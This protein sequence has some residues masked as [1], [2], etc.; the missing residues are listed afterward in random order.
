MRRATIPWACALLVNCG[1]IGFDSSPPVS[2][3]DSGGQTGPAACAP[4]VTGT[5]GATSPFARVQ[6]VPSN[7]AEGTSCQIIQEASSQSQTIS[8][9][10]GN[11]L[12]AFAYGGQA[13]NTSPG[14]TAPNM[15]FT[16]TDTLGNTYLPGS[17]VNNA[18][19][20]DSAIQMFFVPNVRGGANTVTVTETAPQQEDFWTGL[21]LLEYSGVATTDVV[22]LASSE[23]APSSAAIATAPPMTTRAEC[24]LVVGGMANGH[25][26]NSHDTSGSGWAEPLLDEWDPAVFVDNASSGASQGDSVSVSINQQLGADD[27]WV[28]T[29]MAFRAATATAPCQPTGLAFTTVPQSVAHSTCSGST[30]I[31]SVGTAEMTT[32]NGIAV[33]L[34][35]PM[36]FYADSACEFPITSTVIGAGTSSA[37][38]WYIAGQA[39]SPT[40]TASASG[41]AGASQTEI[42][43]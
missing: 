19:Y 26:A 38:F 37:T 35:G 23:G 41:F 33:T 40:I 27:G 20:D 6:V 24:D 28:S 4:P 12:I 1:R 9:T 43:Q 32:P 31:A 3:P 39:G 10:A 14:G 16:V 13:P 34:A 17:Y 8:V 36:K 29:Q 22:D 15:Q 5:C 21:V 42:S 30:T 2:E 7:C 25:V 11:L 18:A